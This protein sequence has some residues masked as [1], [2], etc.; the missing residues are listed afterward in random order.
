MIQ[1]SVNKNNFQVSS[2]KI[3]EVVKKTLV[4]NGVLDAL[5]DVAIV[6]KEKM[7]E[8]NRKYYKDKVYEHPVFTF[9]QNVEID[10]TR[11]LGEI[12]ILN[13]SEEVVIEMAKHGSLHLVGIHH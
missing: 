2:R 12:V 7:S 9:V 3:K 5:V 13:D 8:L 11:Y 6:G 10:G 1:V 4:E